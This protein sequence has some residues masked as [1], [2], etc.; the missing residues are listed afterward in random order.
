MCDVFC[1]GQYVSCVCVYVNMVCSKTITHKRK[2]TTWGHPLTLCRRCVEPLAESLRA[3]IV[4]L[5]F[6]HGFRASHLHKGAQLH[7]RDPKA[8]GMVVLIAL[9]L[10]V[11]ITVGHVP[12]SGEYCLVSLDAELKRIVN[13]KITGGDKDQQS[14][15][16]PG[17]VAGRF[18]C[19]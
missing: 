11:K 5:D 7:E 14:G 1:A 2:D 3:P 10:G 6:D 18:E 8:P 9:V 15:P 19:V 12:H 4:L 17:S 16:P 13:K